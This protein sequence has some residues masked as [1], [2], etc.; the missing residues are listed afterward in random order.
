M[1]SRRMSSSSQ[2]ESHRDRKSTRLNSSHSSISYAVFCLKKKSARL[3]EVVDL[4]TPPLPEAT[5]ITCLTPGMPDA[6][7]V[8]RALRSGGIADIGCSR[9]K[10]IV[11]LDIA[12]FFF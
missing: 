10:R 5:A 1:P 11:L 3:Q 2:G 6:F 12:R 7:E 4:P 9:S 8:A